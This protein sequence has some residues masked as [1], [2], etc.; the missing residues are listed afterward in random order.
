M[1]RQYLKYMY[2]IVLLRNQSCQVMY[3]AVIQIITCTMQL[4]YITF[5]ENKYET[6]RKKVACML[7]ELFSTGHVT[8]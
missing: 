1:T 3:H 7:Y 8:R 2:A 6:I 4:Y 5:F